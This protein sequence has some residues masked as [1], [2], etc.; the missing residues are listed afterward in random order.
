MHRP[1]LVP[2]L[3]GQV[4]GQGHPSWNPDS[5]LFGNTRGR[6]TPCPLASRQQVRSGPKE[7]TAA[8]LGPRVSV[9]PSSSLAACTLRHLQ[10]NV[11]FLIFR[12]PHT[13][14][15]S[16]AG[17]FHSTSEARYPF[18][19]SAQELGLSLHYQ[20]SLCSPL[21]TDHGTRIWQMETFP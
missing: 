5:L 9:P 13:Q 17:H 1:S 2:D 15:C 7:P 21:G 11:Q 12:R 20:R 18:P 19:W 8:T 14:V 16:L 10:V 4:W 3:G 6:D